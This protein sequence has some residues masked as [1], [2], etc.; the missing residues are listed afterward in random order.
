MPDLP[1]AN[2]QKHELHDRIRKS[3][4]INPEPNAF[5]PVL[6]FY[7][8]VLENALIITWLPSKEG[9][10]A[11]PTLNDLGMLCCGVAGTLRENE[12]GAQQMGGFSPSAVQKY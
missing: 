8:Y 9:T 7:I 11:D 2:C 12:D 4:T 6:A 5:I 10:L 3:Q 1:E